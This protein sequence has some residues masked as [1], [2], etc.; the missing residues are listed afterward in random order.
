MLPRRGGAS[1]GLT[2]SARATQFPLVS[3]EVVVLQALG[4]C[5]MVNKPQVN[6]GEP[7]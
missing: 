4:D 7:T 1:S 5:N 2:E 6:Q 3:A